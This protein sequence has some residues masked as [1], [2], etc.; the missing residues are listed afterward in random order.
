[1]LN[2]YRNRPPTSI[3]TAYGSVAKL[4]RIHKCSKPH[5]LRVGRGQARDAAVLRSIERERARLKLKTEEANA[6]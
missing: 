4:A 1:M 2:P 5:V 3:G 6:P